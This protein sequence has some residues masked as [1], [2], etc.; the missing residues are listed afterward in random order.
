[1]SIEDETPTLPVG[2]LLSR[3]LLHLCRSRPF[4]DGTRGVSTKFRDGLSTP[5]PQTPLLPPTCRMLLTLPSGHGTFR[6]ARLCLRLSPLSNLYPLSQLERASGCMATSLAAEARGPLSCPR[7]LCTRCVRCL[8]R[9]TESMWYKTCWRQWKGPAFDARLR[10]AR[11]ASRLVSLAS[12]RFHAEGLVRGDTC[13]ATTSA[14][15]QEGI[16]LT[17][18][19]ALLWRGQEETRSTARG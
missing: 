18:L 5:L 16:M 9:S 11:R 8:G 13:W 19:C 6:M 10:H 17:D 12:L 2:V 7:C 3:I 14:G 4:T 15:R 1:M